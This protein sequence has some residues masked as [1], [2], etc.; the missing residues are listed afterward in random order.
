MDEWCGVALHDCKD[1]NELDE[2][3]HVIG[4]HPA[5]NM[6]WATCLM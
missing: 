2:P 6:Q 4:R 5:A 3:V 1:A